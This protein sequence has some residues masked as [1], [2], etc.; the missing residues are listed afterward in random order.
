[1]TFH[2]P[3]ISAT[4]SPKQGMCISLPCQGP[5]WSETPQ[6]SAV[7]AAPFGLPQPL[8]AFPPLES[9]STL[10]SRLILLSHCS[11]LLCLVGSSFSSRAHPT[12]SSFRAP[13][14]GQLSEIPELVKLGEVLPAALSV[15]T[16]PGGFGS[17]EEHTVKH[18]GFAER[19][20]MV[21]P[22]ALLC[23]QISHRNVFSVWAE[24]NGPRAHGLAQRGLLQVCVGK[25]VLADVQGQAGSVCFS[26][27]VSLMSLDLQLY[28]E[29]RYFRLQSQPD[30]LF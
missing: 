26:S 11:S 19:Q 7:F 16:S 2:F 14:M 15:G 29:N 12:E 22:L 30:S 6:A 5:P 9:A 23:F 17:T 3:G 4:F 8:R 10:L 1:M 24:G 25:A 18:R 20:V 13:R 28:E 27:P 21:S